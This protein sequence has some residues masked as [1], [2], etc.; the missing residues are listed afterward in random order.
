MRWFI[1]LSWEMIR[2]HP[3]WGVAMVL[4][5]TYITASTVIDVRDAHYGS[6]AFLLL[7]NAFAGWLGWQIGQRR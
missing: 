3:L 5:L 2:A 6:A 7:A 1:R 4:N